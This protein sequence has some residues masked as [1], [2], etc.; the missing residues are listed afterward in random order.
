[1]SKTDKEWQVNQTH[2]HSH[3]SICLYP[4]SSIAICDACQAKYANTV[5]ILRSRQAESQTRIADILKVC[6]T[7]SQ[8]SSTINA[9][10]DDRAAIGNTG[11]ADHPCNSLDCPVFFERIKAKNDIRATT[12]YDELLNK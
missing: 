12:T 9:P 3:T 10:T 7:C 1:M 4:I 2:T 8:V 11:F 5:Y 6:D